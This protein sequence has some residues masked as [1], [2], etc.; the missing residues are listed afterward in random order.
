MESKAATGLKMQEISTSTILRQRDPGMGSTV[1]RAG[2]IF[3]AL[4]S[5]GSN[6]TTR[7]MSVQLSQAMSWPHGFHISKLRIPI[8]DSEYYVVSDIEQ[9]PY[10]PN[11]SQCSQRCDGAGNRGPKLD[12]ERDSFAF[13]EEFS[14]SPWFTVIVAYA[15]DELSSMNRKRSSSSSKASKAFQSLERGTRR[16]RTDDHSPKDVV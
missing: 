4:F 1:Q 6:A 11:G 14:H 3:V 7:A 15:Y 5:T 10:L 13:L 2:R 9:A 16:V 8:K 12:T